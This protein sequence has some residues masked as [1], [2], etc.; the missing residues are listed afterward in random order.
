MVVDTEKC[1]STAL[2]RDI[3]NVTVDELVS[4][5]LNSRVLV[6]RIMSLSAMHRINH[7]MDW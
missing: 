4:A 5:E 1:F 2:F 7:L 3:I 6:R